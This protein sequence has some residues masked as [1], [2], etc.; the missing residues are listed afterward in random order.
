[1]AF[2]PFESNYADFIIVTLGK[3]QVSTFNASTSPLQ[4]FGYKGVY[5]KNS[6]SKHMEYN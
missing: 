3:S 2:I 1:V 6:Q 5:R 4:G